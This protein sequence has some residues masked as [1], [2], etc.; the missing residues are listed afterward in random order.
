MRIRTGGA[1]AALLLALAL[2]VAGCGS[3]G[4]TDEAADL[5]AEANAQD[6]M[7]VKFAECLGEHGVNVETGEGGGIRITGRVPKEKVDAAMEACR[8]YSPMQN[9]GSPD[10]QAEERMRKMAQCMRDN[11]VEDFPDPE[12]GRGIQ[13]DRSVAEDPDFEEAQKECEKYAPAGGQRSTETHGDD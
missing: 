10:P 12:P 6:E 2:A 4:E 3:D 1:R 11:G 7:A 13:L 8:E 5:A 9:G